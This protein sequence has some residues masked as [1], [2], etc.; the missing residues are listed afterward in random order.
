MGFG[1]DR[2]LTPPFPRLPVIVALPENDLRSPVFSGLVD[3]GA[4][5]TLIPTQ[6]LRDLNAVEIYVARL[7]SHWG[8]PRAVSVYL[9]DLDIAGH[10][11]PGVEVVADDHAAD[12][13]LGRNVLNRLILLLDGPDGMAEV[14]PHRPRLRTTSARPVK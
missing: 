13:L 3:T 14:L 10:R 1:Y 6:Q 2:N 9:V 12:V 4:D 11:L 7:R 5:A 8:E